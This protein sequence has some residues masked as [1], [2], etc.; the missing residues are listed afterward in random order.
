MTG[1]SRA[2]EEMLSGV[3]LFAGLSKRQAKRLIERAARSRTSGVA[4]SPAKAEAP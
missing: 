1:S 2:P 4:R 3:D